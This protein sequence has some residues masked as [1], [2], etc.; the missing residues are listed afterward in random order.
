[1]SHELFQL[2]TPHH[3]ISIALANTQRTQALFEKVMASAG[4]P[5]AQRL[6]AEISAEGSD[7]IRHLREALARTP[8][9]MLWNEDTLDLLPRLFSTGA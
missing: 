9:P 8:A 6:A 4:D 3:A 2:L 5:D 1:V 7:Q